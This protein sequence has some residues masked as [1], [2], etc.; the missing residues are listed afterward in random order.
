MKKVQVDSGSESSVSTPTSELTDGTD[1]QQESFDGRKHT[2]LDIKKI[3]S[4]P[5]TPV[6]LQNKPSL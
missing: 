1:N 4:Q 3:E 2:V 5:L 6:K